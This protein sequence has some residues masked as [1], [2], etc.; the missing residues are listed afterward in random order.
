MSQNTKKSKILTKVTP[1]LSQFPIYCPNN[2]KAIANND[3]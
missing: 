3:I 2:D 1:F